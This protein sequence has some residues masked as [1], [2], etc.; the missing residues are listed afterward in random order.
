MLASCQCPPPL[1]FK[2]S[3]YLCS[4]MMNETPCSTQRRAARRRASERERHREAQPAGECIA[5]RAPIQ[6]VSGAAALLFGGLPSFS[7][8][9]RRAE[10]WL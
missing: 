9:A 4:S 8:A 6:L 2:R 3:A 10:M 7:T 5:R 1:N